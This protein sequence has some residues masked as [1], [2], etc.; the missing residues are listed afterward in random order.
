MVYDLVGTQV[1][2]HLEFSAPIVY[3][4]FSQDGKRLFVLTTDQTAYVFDVAAVDVSM[5]TK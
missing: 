4:S 3:K 5:K 1:W 2:R